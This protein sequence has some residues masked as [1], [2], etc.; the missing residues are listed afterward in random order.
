MGHPEDA[1]PTFEAVLKLVPS[2][3]PSWG[4][5]G[6]AYVQLHRP[7]EAERCLLKALEYRPDYEL[8]QK[9]LLSLR[10]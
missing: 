1:I 7:S 5:L 8:A 9:N 3:Y 4:N 6:A 10:E 2:H